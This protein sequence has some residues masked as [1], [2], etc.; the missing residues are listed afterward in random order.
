[1]GENKDISD[2]AAKVNGDK[3]SILLSYAVKVV[4]IL[5]IMFIIDVTTSYLIYQKA[6]GVIFGGVSIGGILYYI[7]SYYMLFTIIPLILQFIGTR[8]VICNSNNDNPVSFTFFLIIFSFVLSIS[9]FICIQ[10][11]MPYSFSDYIFRL[12]SCLREFCTIYLWK[13]FAIIYAL[14]K[15]SAMFLYVFSVFL[16]HR[17]LS[18]IT[19][20]IFWAVSN[21]IFVNNND[22][23]SEDKEYFLSIRNF[24][25]V[26]IVVYLF[27][28]PLYCML[29]YDNY[30]ENPL[31]S[32]MLLIQAGVISVAII[33]MAKKV[34][35]VGDDDKRTIIKI[36]L[37]SLLFPL[38][39][40]LL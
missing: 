5:P 4:S 40:K 12:S 8:N 17:T 20:M 13:H 19:V 1:M 3:I 22:I 9:I 35:D 34:T 30:S 31:A 29:K 21:Y 7:V 32:L 16:S 10:Y 11:W 38:L 25:V 26:C 28:Y 33:V 39:V 24:W 23:T 2:S 18:L 6:H 36:I 37:V 15:L 27:A 14:I